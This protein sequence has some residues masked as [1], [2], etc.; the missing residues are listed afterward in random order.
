M[1][2]PMTTVTK[3]FKCPICSQWVNYDYTGPKKRG[4]FFSSKEHAWLGHM[5][6]TPD[7][8]GESFLNAFYETKS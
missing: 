8:Q 6:T 7:H 2:N 1:E 4:D 3:R 5:N